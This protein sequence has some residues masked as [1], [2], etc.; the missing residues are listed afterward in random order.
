MRTPIEISGQTFKSPKRCEI[1]VCQVSL[2]RVR[3][4]LTSP[5]GRLA[6]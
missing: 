3:A 2:I 6:V 4:L 1:Q 5:S